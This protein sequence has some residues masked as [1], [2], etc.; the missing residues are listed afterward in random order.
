MDLCNY[1]N[2]ESGPSSH[3]SLRKLP[4]RR[5]QSESVEPHFATDFAGKKDLTDTFDW[6]EYQTESSSPSP[7]SD[8]SDRPT[9]SNSKLSR[10]NRSDGNA[11]GEDVSP[12]WEK[13]KNATKGKLAIKI[14]NSRSKTRPLELQDSNFL[15]N[16]E[17]EAIVSINQ[18][19]IQDDE[20]PIELQLQ[21]KDEIPITLQ[22]QEEG[23]QFREKDFFDWL[24]SKTAKSSAAA[25]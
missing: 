16:E 2:F 15:L 24:L 10:G 12:V 19:Q 4:G 9:Q 14:R 18:L 8:T 3:K 1:E 25:Q 23:V 22:I 20:I 13:S 5:C 17:D 21:E 11:N 6:K 7:S